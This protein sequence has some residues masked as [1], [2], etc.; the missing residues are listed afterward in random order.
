[1]VQVRCAVG[2]LCCVLHIQDTASFPQILW[3]IGLYRMTK[4]HHRIDGKKW[5]RTTDGIT[6]APSAA[7]VQTRQSRVGKAVTKGRHGPQD[8]LRVRRVA[9]CTPKRGRGN[10]AD[11][12]VDGGW[13]RGTDSSGP[14][15]PTVKGCIHKQR[16]ASGPEVEAER[17]Q[18]ACVWACACA[19]A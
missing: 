16:R 6:A 13:G 17:G 9:V 2:S 4:G 1:M 15:A 11:E 12:I 3:P 18:L 19:C 14:G 10:V 7:A 5:T 8:M